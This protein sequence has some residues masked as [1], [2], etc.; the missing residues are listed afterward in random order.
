MLNFKRTRQSEWKRERARERCILFLELSWLLESHGAR[1]HSHV[2]WGHLSRWTHH[3]AGIHAHATVH[4]HHHA[5]HTTTHHHA[6]HATWR[7]ELRAKA[8]C[9]K[10][11]SL[12]ANR[13]E[14]IKEVSEAV[15]KWL[16]NKVE[17]DSNI[18]S[19]LCT[20]EGTHAKEHTKGES[21]G[22]LNT[23]YPL[24]FRHCWAIKAGQTKQAFHTDVSALCALAYPLL[25]GIR[26]SVRRPG[27]VRVLLLLLLH[28][29]LHLHHLLC[30]SW[31]CHSSHP[32]HSSTE[33]L[34]LWAS[35]HIA[36][37]ARACLH[38]CSK[39]TRLGSHILIWVVHN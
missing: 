23:R 28:H 25:P 6:P 38:I 21:Y 39:A 11:V 2:H 17:F 16:C 31:V 37:A 5:R 7:T 13:A 29:L 35:H 1:V 10:L 24:H 22:R 15:A 19:W 33:A 34:L 4:T 32:S 18:S 12:L 30:L 3:R 36:H 8:S 14:W 9:P 27:H 20:D 26:A